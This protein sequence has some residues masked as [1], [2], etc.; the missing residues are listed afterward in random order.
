LERLLLTI[1]LAGLRSNVQMA[2]P[3]P[4]MSADW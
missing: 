4:P 3:A 1:W 2:A